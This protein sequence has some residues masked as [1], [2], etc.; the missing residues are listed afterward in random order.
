MKR[1]RALTA[2]ITAVA[3]CGLITV[4]CGVV[5]LA[6]TDEAATQPT[7]IQDEAAGY[8]LYQSTNLRVEIHRQTDP[9]TPLIWYEAD[10]QCS[11]ASLLACVLSAEKRTYKHLK[12]PDTIAQENNLIYAQTDDFFGDRVGSKKLKTGVV[13]RGGVLLYDDVYH[14]NGKPFPPLDT[15]AVFPDGT[16]ETFGAGEYTGEQYL[17]MGAR[18]VISFGP[19]LIRDGAIDARLENGY[20]DHEPRCAIGMIAPYH[21]VSIVV[22]G[23]HE[24]SAGCGLK[25]IAE[26]ML[27]L[28]VT[29]AINLDGGQTAAMIFMGQQ[30]NQT[31]K[32]KTTTSPRSVSGVLGIADTQSQQ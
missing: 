30:L 20:A 25:R 31:G 11:E 28:G 9:D 22:E 13:I 4:F 23:R 3:V 10:L 17:F 26:R 8:W 32:F 2:F 1:F 27:E 7:V 19:I 14:G 21:Y 6:Q 12:K 29:E 18:D 24:G 15:L 5:A 16:L